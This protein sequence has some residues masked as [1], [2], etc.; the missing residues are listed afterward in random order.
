MQIWGNV[1]SMEGETILWMLCAHK[2]GMYEFCSICI[3]R[4][5]SGV[6]NGI[7]CKSIA[8]SMPDTRVG[9]VLDV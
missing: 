1:D 5:T 3:R 8:L 6:P 9:F 7:G 4:C 2:P